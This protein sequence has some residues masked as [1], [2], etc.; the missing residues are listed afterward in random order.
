[1]TDLFI[2][3]GSSRGL[4]EAL[5]RLAVEDGHQVYGISRSASSFG[6]WLAGDLSNPVAVA[7]TVADTLKREGSNDYDNY[8]LINNGA[9]L[10]V[11]SRHDWHTIDTNLVVNL[12]AHML[13]SRVF[14]EALEDVSAR[15][16]IVN[17]SSGAATNAYHGWSLYCSTKAGLEHF[18]RCV[19]LEEKAASNPVDV[20]SLSP[21]VIDTGMQTQIRGASIA[22]FPQ[23]PR[24]QALHADGALQSPDDVAA[25]LL[26]G[27]RFDHSFGG[28]TLRVD[29]LVG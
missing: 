18:G 13:L 8:I 20:M 9:M 29:E 14:I 25:R 7:E 21:G 24:F 27:I 4:G 22:D 28:K 3:S 5:C 10:D 26:K 1:M 23:L 19:A 17:I 6:T 12:G 11:G 2:V 16:L 15:K